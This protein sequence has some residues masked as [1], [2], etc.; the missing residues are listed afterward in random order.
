MHK[1]KYILQFSLFSSTKTPKTW[2]GVFEKILFTWIPDYTAWCVGYYT[3][4]LELDQMVYEAVRNRYTWLAVQSEYTTS[5]HL[6]QN[7]HSIRK[8][9]FW[10][11]S[12]VN[13]VHLVK[14]C[15]CLK[16]SEGKNSKRT[17]VIHDRPSAE[18]FD[19]LWGQTQGHRAQQPQ[20]SGTS[21]V[22]VVLETRS[23][24]SRWVYRTMGK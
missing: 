1:D 22:L 14:Y 7:N 5:N 15:T 11:H 3:R 21:F 9:G 23:I 24:A 10:G 4:G 6:N 17:Q 18:L 19:V 8:K 2:V 12:R 16:A 13:I 20:S